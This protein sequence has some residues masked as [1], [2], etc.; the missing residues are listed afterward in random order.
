M[1]TKKEK[2]AYNK[3]YRARP[4]VKAK[5]RAEAKEYYAKN[6]LA[7][8]AKQKN[9]TQEGKARKKEH[10]EAWRTK[11]ETKVRQKAYDK[12][13]RATPEGRNTRR[14]SSRKRRALNRGVGHTKYNDLDIFKRDNW[15]CQICGKK[16]DR[17][18]KWPN[19]A[20]KSIDHI[21]PISKGGDDKP[22]N[23]QATHLFCNMSK[24][25][26]IIGQARL[27]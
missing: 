17:R 26:K 16:I 14:A 6:R 21:I 9:I 19:T 23:I 8:I 4:E 7:I 3:V 22:S 2:A 5:R 27:A 25:D 18:F 15:T 1:Q 11:P 24:H 13:R 12:A 20:S 10:Q